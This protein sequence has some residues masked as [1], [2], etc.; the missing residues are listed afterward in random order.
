MAGVWRHAAC[1][2][3][4]TEKVALGISLATWPSMS[5]KAAGSLDRLHSGF[6][7]SPHIC[8]SNHFRKTVV[9]GFAFLALPISE[10]E[11]SNER[12]P[13]SADSPS[14]SFLFHIVRT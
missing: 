7:F 6:F 12:R 14:R 10:R 4:Y 1:G 13:K 5:A 8:L 9:L 3:N 2:I 11:A